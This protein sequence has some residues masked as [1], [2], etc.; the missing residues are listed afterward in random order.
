[1]LVMNRAHGHLYITFQ[2][3]CV[4]ANEIPHLSPTLCSVS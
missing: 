3:G 4:Y 2:L 1:M